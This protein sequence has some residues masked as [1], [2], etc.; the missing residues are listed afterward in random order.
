MQS[1]GRQAAFFALQDEE[2]ESG[3]GQEDEQFPANDYRIGK[4]AREC[5]GII[6]YDQGSY[7]CS[8]H[9]A[10][11]GYRGDV[12]KCHIIKDLGNKYA[13]SPNCYRYLKHILHPGI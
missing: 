6:T 5:I 1:D 12:S 9:K 4:F 3:S 13:K 10:Q 2:D 11:Q 8:E 7:G